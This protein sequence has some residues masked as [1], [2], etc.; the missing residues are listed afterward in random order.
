MCTKLY[1]I[2][3]LEIINAVGEKDTPVHSLKADLLCN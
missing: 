1:L 3:S 2:R